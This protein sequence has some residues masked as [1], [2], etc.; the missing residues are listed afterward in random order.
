LSKINSINVLYHGSKI[1][2]LSISRIA[3]WNAGKKAINSTD[4]VKKDKFRIE[5]DKEFKILE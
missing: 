4:I 2:N 3:I 5:I 1:E